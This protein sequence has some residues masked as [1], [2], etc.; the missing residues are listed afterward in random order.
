MYCTQ[1]SKAQADSSMITIE[2]VLRAPDMFLVSG[3]TF[4]E[5]KT[6][7][8]PEPSAWSIYGRPRDRRHM[9]TFQHHRVVKQINRR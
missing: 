3:S 5:D 1:A 6:R 8:M 9:H 2:K 7:E 4:S